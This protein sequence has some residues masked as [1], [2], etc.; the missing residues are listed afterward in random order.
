M[1]MALIK[2]RVLL[3][4]DKFVFAYEYSERMKISYKQPEGAG[5][6]VGLDNSRRIF[7]PDISITEF[8]AEIS[9]L[10]RMRQIVAEAALE[11][12]K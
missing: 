3:D 8:L 6:L 4:L 7:I 9:D 5:I 12:K 10:K 1:K 2:D 11:T